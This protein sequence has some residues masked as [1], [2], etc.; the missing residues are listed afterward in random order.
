MVID[1]MLTSLS[2]F[3]SSYRATVSPS[4]LHRGYETSTREAS[5][6]PAA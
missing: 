5:A 4:R 6:A 1:I 3:T 2:M